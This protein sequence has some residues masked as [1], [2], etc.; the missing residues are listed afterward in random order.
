MVALL[1]E[2]GTLQEA[3]QLVAQEYAQAMQ[4]LEQLPQT[5]AQHLLRELIAQLEQRSY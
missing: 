5:P 2:L 1:D 4:I 3:R